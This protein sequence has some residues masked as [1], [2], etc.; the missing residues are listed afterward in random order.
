MQSISKPISKN[1]PPEKD[2]VKDQ[3]SLALPTALPF[4]L[5]ANNISRDI[6]FF[7]LK[8]APLLIR[9]KDLPKSC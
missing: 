3:V 8:T 5:P 4:H 9:E 2:T 6:A 1:A 7:A